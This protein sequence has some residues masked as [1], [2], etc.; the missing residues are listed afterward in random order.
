VKASDD[1]PDPLTPVTT[2]RVFFSKEISI[3]LRLWVVTHVRSIVLD[4]GKKRRERYESIGKYKR[5]ANI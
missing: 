4:I 3:F 1:L 5:V 2:V